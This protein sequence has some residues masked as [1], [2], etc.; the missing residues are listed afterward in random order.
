MKTP[1]IAIGLGGILG[2][3]ALL[4]LFS[5]TETDA[6]PSSFHTGPSGLAA[7]E[8]LLEKD[9]YQ[10]TSNRSPLLPTNGDELVIAPVIMDKPGGFYSIVSGETTS[11]IERALSR[12]AAKGGKLLQLQIPQDFNKASRDSAVFTA[13]SSASKFKVRA[14]LPVS[15]PPKMAHDATDPSTGK[16][17]KLS[18]PMPLFSF[19]EKTTLGGGQIPAARIQTV[20]E[21]TVIS[22]DSGII[23]VNRHLADENNA[24]LVL[25]LV[26]RLA[27]AGSKVVFAE[28]SIGN[29]T[30]GGLGGALGTWFS[31]ARNQAILLFVTVSV[32][33][34]VRFGRRRPTRH[35]VKGARDMV[36]AL[37][38]QLAGTNDRVF[39]LKCIASQVESELKR[40]EGLGSH[41][42]SKALAMVL[43]EREKQVLNYVLEL[44]ADAAIPK[45]HAAKI[46]SDLEGVLASARQRVKER[47]LIKS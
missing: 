23:A 22:L 32:T 30:E 4:L 44:P 25:E 26:R 35:S 31:A 16:E 42:D 3:C 21:G 1:H 19:A 27:P 28:A 7:L 34:A 17:V 37:A 5:K 29:Q 12:H 39:V 13:Q 15:E 38:T 24:G 47:S 33:F 14:Y 10:T 40:L 8:R 6:W 2:F 20:G 36:D 18:E 41:S 46:A 45:S 43:P 11:P 9:G